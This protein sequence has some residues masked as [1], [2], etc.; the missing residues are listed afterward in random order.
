MAC[1]TRAGQLLVLLLLTACAGTAPLTPEPDAASRLRYQQRVERLQ[2]VPGFELGGR[3]AVTGAALSGS[4]RWTQGT[5]GFELRVNGP[6]GAG[7]MELSGDGKTVR[8][9][10]KDV[11]L[12][13][14]QPER[15]LFETS[16]WPLPLDALRYWVLGVPAP[17]PFEGLVIDADGRVLKLRQNGWDLDFSDYHD[18]LPETPGR[19]EARHEAL[20]AT[21]I[22]RRLDFPAA[23]AP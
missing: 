5:E 12:S 23:P 9:R 14:D 13:T 8:I 18:A 19:L 11:D 7:A 21:L 6:F 10:S 4:L 20:A 1:S 22:V 3:I 17:G 15:L 16:G 2:G